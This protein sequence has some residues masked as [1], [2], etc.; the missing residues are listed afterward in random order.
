MA[1]HDA[2][3]IGSGPNGLAAAIHLAR[4]GWKVKVIEG[5]DTIGGGTRTKELTLPGFKHDVCSAS[6]PMGVASPFMRGLDLEARG[7][8]WLQPKVPLAHP[9]EDGRAGVLH[10]SLDETCAGLGKDG[11]IYRRY[12]APLVKKADDLFGDILRPARLPRHPITMTRFGVGA[13]MPAMVFASI[14]DT[15][16][17]RALFGGNAAHSI[18][19]LEKFFTTAIGL[20]LQICAHSVGWPIPEGGSQRIT[21]TMADIL[22]GLGGEIQCGWQVNT[23]AELPPAK[24][25]LFDVSP[26][27]L[28]RICGDALPG[29][30]RLKLEAFR[31]GPGVF[32]V[33]YA[34]NAPIPWTNEW[35]R[36]A[37]VVH[38]G[39]TIEE[40]ATSERE[41]WFGKHPAKPFILV[42]QPTLDDP[43]RAPAGKHIAWAYCHVPA[44]STTD[45]LEAMNAQ[46]ERFAPGFRD[47]VLAQHTMNCAQMED[48][49]ANYIGGD[50]VGG[51][52]DLRQLF[53]RPAG[54]IQPYATPNPRVF[55]CS[56]ST[57]PGGGVHGMCGYWAAKCV[58]KRVRV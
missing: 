28:S 57:P 51:V 52:N 41:S 1:D 54:L 46:I 35:C 14:F 10:R 20:V 24:A 45:M 16:E 4:N 23:L 53:T 18:I 19:P 48:Y 22:R 34:L 40:I 3:I 44:G 7:L 2:L 50:V 27:N 21:E 8:R 37:G 43:S 13:M 12:F 29:R 25:L 6:H 33:D 9:L 49:N 39:G 56:A 30:Y 11:A 26:R 17:G 55:L 42:N 15:E 32:K 47:C 38:V 5:A 36:K 31:H 58:L